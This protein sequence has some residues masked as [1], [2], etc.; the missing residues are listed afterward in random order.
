[1]IHYGFE[2]ACLRFQLFHP[3][4][5]AFVTFTVPT[6][7]LH[8][9]DGSSELGDAALTLDAVDLRRR[10]D[11][12]L[13]RYFPPTESS[14]LLDDAR[15]RV[16]LA[17]GRRETEAAWLLRLVSHQTPLICCLVRDLNEIRWTEE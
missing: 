7:T 4:T 12:R 14:L 17:Y 2:A 16:M 13:G 15:D 3:P 5:A 8:V 9:R 11:I 10:L 1:L 6:D